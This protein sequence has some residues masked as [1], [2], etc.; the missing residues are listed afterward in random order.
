[1]F[2]FCSR[3]LII[4]G[5]QIKFNGTTVEL[6]NLAENYVK[7]IVVEK[8]HYESELKNRLKI[9]TIKQDGAGLVKI[10][11]DG[12]FSDT[13]GSK[14]VQADLEEAYKILLNSSELG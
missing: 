6:I 12:R 10:H 8:N 7:E 4:S 13:P 2:N 5:A 11:F 14:S 1:M 9:I 3:L